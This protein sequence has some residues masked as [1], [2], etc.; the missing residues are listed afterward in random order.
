MKRL[1]NLIRR[2]PRLFAGAAV[3]LLAG[4]ALF[5]LRSSGSADAAAG[6]AGAT[7][8]AHTAGSTVPPTAAAVSITTPT[9]RPTGHGGGTGPGTPAAAP[10]SR[11]VSN[12]LRQATGLSPSQVAA[13]RLCPTA[14][15]GHARCAGEKLVVRS[16]GAV[17]HPRITAR[18]SVRPA[19]GSSVAPPSAFT[20][21]YLQQAYDIASLSKSGGSGDTVA[22]VDA[23]DDPTAESDLAVYRSFY[24]LP[25]CTTG[26]GCFRKVNQSGGSTPPSISDPGW[27]QEI[28]LD[29]DAVSAICPNC[30]ILLVEA[31]STSLTD[32]TAAMQTAHALG[33]KQ[34]SDSWTVTS[35]SVPSG[36]FTWSGVATVAATGDAGYL[37]PDSSGP[38]DNFPAALPGVTA[39]GGTTL[40][41]ASSANARGFSEGAWFGGGSGCN[42]D[43]GIVKPSYQTDN[44][45]KGRSYAD[46]S[47]DADPNTGLSV[48]E[49]G[50]WSVVGGTSLATPVIAAYYAI[51]ATNNA[52]PQWAYTNSGAFNDIVTGS[53]G[54]CSHNIAYI[55]TAG[56]GYDGPTGVGSIS[57]DAVTGAPGIGGPAITTPSGANTYTKSTRS[58]GATISGGIY[59]NGLDTT[60]WIQY[61]PASGGSVQ[62]TPATDIGSGTTAVT[63]SGYPSHLASN[64]QYRYRLVATNSAGITYGYTY[65]FTT[66]AASSSTPVAAFAFSPTAS[67]P[68]S[69]VSFNATGSTDSGAT[70][71]D[72]SW[73]FGDGST[74]DAGNAPTTSHA[75]ANPG[76]YRV[77][78][79]VTNNNGEGETTT[80]IVTV[81]APPTASFTASA[82]FNTPASFDASG[83][84]DPVGTITDYSWNFGD[85]S[86]SQDG[87]STP[88][89]S[90][91]FAARGN[92]S[93]T[94]TVKNDAGQTATSTQGLIVDDPPTVQL[95]ASAVVTPN[96]P[97]SFNATAASD[98]PIATWS[99]NFG[100]PGSATNTATVQNPTHTYATPGTYTVTVTATDDLGVRASATQTV[101]VDAPPAASFTAS[102]TFTTPA[103]FD[104]SGS[105]DSVG[106]ITSYRWDFGDPD[107][108]DNTGTGPNP[109]HAYARRGSYTVTLTVT[110]DAGQ[111]A[112]TTKTVTVDDPPTVS[113]TATPSPTQPTLPVS[114]DATAIPD[115]GG[116]IA[117]Y[118]WN[119]GDGSGTQDG[120]STPTM[121]HTYTTPG[122]YS[123]KVTATD[124]LGITGTTTGHVTVDAPPTPSFLAS[125][126]QPSPTTAVGFDA[127]GSS[128]SVGTITDYSWNFGD[129]STQDGGSTPTAS[130]AFATRGSYTI[131][132]TVTNDAGQTATSTQTVT[133]DDPP[134]ATPTPSTTLTTPGSTVSFTSIAASPTIVG[135]SWNF[136]DPGSA[137]NAATVAN[138]TH[139]YASPGVYSV[140]L[141]VIDDLG[142]STKKTVQLTVDAAPTAAFTASAN[143]ATAG[144]PVGFD[145]SGSTDSVGT[146][147]GY[148]WNFGDPGSAENTSTGRNPT[149][150]YAT[151]GSYTVSLTVTNDAGQSSIRNAAVTVNSVPV[152]TPPTPQP[153]SPPVR[154]QTPPAPT[155]APTP[156]AAS[157]AAAKKQKL[158]SVLPHGLGL[159]LTVSQDI[160]ATFQ[161]TLPASQ[162]RFAHGK[163][164]T[165]VLLNTRAQT[166]GAGTHPITLKLSRAAQRQLSARGPLVV[167]VRVTLNSAGGTVTRSLKITLTR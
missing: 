97:V 78:L 48:Y 68:G 92:Y 76:I 17:V 129:G 46:V 146:I 106:T 154:A 47:A 66:G 155:P 111:T 105:T 59:P 104:A 133:V 25:A 85:G 144:L 125:S 10:T 16:T 65:G 5:A 8:S 131:T 30:H 93:V 150:V 166:L 71:T 122:T 135:Y 64:T 137:Q 21:A 138:P 88:T 128:D 134:T 54:S 69:A 142:V 161:I 165:I 120:G 87:G 86:G 119:F 22:I 20:P 103:T 33:A 123:V 35:S 51:T 83:S 27:N 107:S 18:G 55:C 24:G 124:E 50:S 110:N 57:G 32:L 118:S 127:R 7:A 157:L 121:S 11:G 53:N 15:I 4:T 116:T 23:Y 80:Q 130:H 132:L 26:N 38:H 74:Q 141:T 113:L 98:G 82:T 145:A 90:H 37:A 9:R 60:W 43:A 42:R 1:L 40:A 102:P 112:T 167:T 149:H 73:D 143:P 45:C 151:P 2:H 96:L 108:G 100:D 56:P 14:A 12:Q 147:T 109:A 153:P 29:L 117:D 152:V 159:S 67:K 156:L 114:F 6:S 44:G 139:A 3:I 162:S 36:T 89:M 34:I 58:D 101:T 13:R 160:T 163:A 99:W 28:S 84:S 164:K 63:V 70:I 61:W 91:T 126:N 77:T 158:A 148:A 62:Q 115:Q 81:D 140:S 41:P 94:L 136:G 52:T 95:T 39:A 31:S 49:A 72:Y 75:Y 79:I 19:D